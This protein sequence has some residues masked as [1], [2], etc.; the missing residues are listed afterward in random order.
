MTSSTSPLPGRARDRERGAATLETTGM[1]IVAALLVVALV[2][3]ASPQ[4]R[5]LGETASYYICQVVTFGQGGCTP[6]ST[7]PEA[8]EPSQPCVISQN[9]IE[10]NQKI[11]VVVVTAADGRRIEVQTLSNGEY[12]VTVTDSGGVGAEVGVGGGLSI[13]VNDRTV[14]GNASAQAGGSLDVKGGDVYYADQDGIDD[15]MDGLLQDQIKDTVVGDGGPVRWLADRG[16]DLLGT[17]ND[18]PEPDETYAEGGISLNASAEATAGTDSASAGVSAAQVLGTRSQRDGTTTVYLRSTVSGSAGLQSLGFDVDGPEFQGASVSGSAQVVTAVTFDR[19]GNMVNVQATSTTSGE[20]KGLA[21]AIFGG[22]G[23]DA[24]SN[25]DSNTTIYQSTLD[26]QDESD[27][28][29][30]N[31]FLLSQGVGALG[32]WTNPGL[33]LQGVASSVNFFEA[34]RSRGTTTRQDYDT[35][36]NTLVGF[37]ASGRLGIE[38]GASGS[39]VQDSMNVSNA[40]Y[41]DGTGWVDWEACAA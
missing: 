4:G 23:D 38:L 31:Q 6:P 36:T 21:T 8:H 18:L 19:E 17:S 39:V 16:T 24:L 35:D 14:G 13:T 33:A 3:V 27:Q 22:S 32:G 41:W 2:M 20:S 30:A 37:D 9:G 29:V 1:A 5:I 26:I 15:L 40:R 7:S 25:S 34:A 11:A 10:R 28:A 12:R